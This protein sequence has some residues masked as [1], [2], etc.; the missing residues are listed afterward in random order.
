MEEKRDTENKSIKG[1]KNKER[2]REIQKREK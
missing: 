2:G 1:D